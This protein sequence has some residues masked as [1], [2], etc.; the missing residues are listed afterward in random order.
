M[1]EIKFNPLA[2]INIVRHALIKPETPDLKHPTYLIYGLLTGSVENDQVLVKSYLPLFHTNN[3]V[4]F[5]SR[6]D[7]FKYAD[8]YNAEHYD[9]DYQND[10]ILGYVR[11][12]PK[13]GDPE[14]VNVTNV[15]KT[16][17]LYFQTA[18]S[19]NAVV[20]CLP[21]DG[22][23]YN[24]KVKRFKGQLAEIDLDSE[25]MD[26]DWNFGEFEDLDE[27]FKIVLDLNLDRVKK[28]PLI[29]ELMP[30]KS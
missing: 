2:Y 10:I 4:N 14:E 30:V 19:E 28:K 29:S 26:V 24:I 9:P 25:L 7:I 13:E 23:Q 8:N 15:D 12:G 3:V 5:E 6:H 11:S 17:L 1:P 21:A 18:Y 27:L 16:N 20:I 22:D